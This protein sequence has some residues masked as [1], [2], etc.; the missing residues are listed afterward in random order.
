MNIDKLVKTTV[1][2]SNGSIKETYDDNYYKITTINDNVITEKWWSDLNVLLFT[3]IT[4]I[5]IDGSIS[6]TIV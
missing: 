4:T 1:F 5:N 6:A 3:R 2:N